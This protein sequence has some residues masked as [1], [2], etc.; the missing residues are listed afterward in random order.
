ML[1]LIHVK[2]KASCLHRI[3]KEAAGIR[4]DCCRCALTC[5]ICC[6]V[7]F[8][9][10]SCQ[11][12]IR[13]DSNSG[14]LSVISFPTKIV[15]NITVRTEY[16]S[17]FLVSWG[18]SSKSKRPIDEELIFTPQSNFRY[19]LCT[20]RNYNV[21]K[22]GIGSTSHIAF[23]FYSKSQKS[24]WTEVSIFVEKSMSLSILRLD[25]SKPEMT[26]LSVP[27]FES[28]LWISNVSRFSFL[29]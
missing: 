26:M 6:L 23:H 3:L 21:E 20:A 27:W 22:N 29:F 17:I 4:S 24:F 12:F 5:Y 13:K 14:Q 2:A 19:W 7:S 10:V 11:N 8:H 1:F 25:H 28:D 9:C 18:T 15:I 16:I